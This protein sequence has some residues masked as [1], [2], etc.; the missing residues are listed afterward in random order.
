MQTLHFEAI[1]HQAID[2]DYAI[3]M[4]SNACGMGI[5]TTFEGW[6]S[7]E[8]RRVHVFNGVKYL[9]IVPWTKPAIRGD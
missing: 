7:N 6:R 8:A 1:F 3:A 5:K 4:I 2:V 9:A